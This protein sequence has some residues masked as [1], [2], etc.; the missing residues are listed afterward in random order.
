M[1]T[2]AGDAVHEG[3]LFLRV[4]EL[5]VGGEVSG[6]RELVRLS[7]VFRWRHGG[8]PRFFAPNT[9]RALVGRLRSSFSAEET[10]GNVPPPFGK[11]CGAEGDVDAIGIVEEN[12]VVSVGV[13][14]DGAA[15]TSAG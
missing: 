10:L 4:G 3:F 5:K 11:L 7:A 6:N 8:L 2:T 9:K 15:L 13:S 14:V 1:A 12:V